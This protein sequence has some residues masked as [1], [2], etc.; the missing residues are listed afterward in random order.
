MLRSI[1]SSAFVQHLQEKGALT[2]ETWFGWTWGNEKNQVPWMNWHHL[3]HTGCRAR[4]H[5]WLE[6][7]L[8]QWS[9]DLRAPN[10]GE[11][12]CLVCPHHRETHHSSG[13]SSLENPLKFAHNTSM[14]CLCGPLLYKSEWSHMIRSD[15]EQKPLT[16]S[17]GSMKSSS[18]NPLVSI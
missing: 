9:S 15:A 18:F 6:I 12:R 2:K 1:S 7:S 8:R 5:K 3:L 13:Y 14:F 11:T 16:T 17:C 10:S 4:S